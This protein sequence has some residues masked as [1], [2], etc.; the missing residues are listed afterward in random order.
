MLWYGINGRPWSPLSTCRDHLFV[1]LFL[2]TNEATNN[3]TFIFSFIMSERKKVTSKS[4]VKEDGEANEGTTN[5]PPPLGSGSDN[6]L[7]TAGS[8]TPYESLI[9]RSTSDMESVSLLT[10]LYGSR[11][12]RIRH[13]AHKGVL[14]L[15]ITR[16]SFAARDSASGFTTTG[17]RQSFTRFGCR[18]TTQCRYYATPII[19][20]I[21]CDQGLHGN[22][23]R[24]GSA[25]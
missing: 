5:S 6:P 3:T 23:P 25:Y 11:G 21:Y 2:I 14:Q 8:A 12:E 22:G 4:K 1:S 10:G 15:A 24:H 16:A 7:S 9:R 17:R 20:R 19:F 18:T 13:V